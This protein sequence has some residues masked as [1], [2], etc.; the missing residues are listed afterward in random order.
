MYIKVKNLLD[1]SSSFS[2][3]SNGESAGV[4]TV[5]VKNI[6][7]FAASQ[8][9]QIGKTKEETAEVVITGTANPSGTSLVLTGTTRF[10]HP[11]DTPVY[12]IRFDQVIFKRSITGTSGVAT[13]LATVGITPD[14]EYTPV[15]YTHLTLPT[16]LLV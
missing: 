1:Q 7:S 11:T 10:D 8:A 2:Y 6:N 5:R 4:G 13:N 15:S 16:I 9:L 3:L 14:S 12:A